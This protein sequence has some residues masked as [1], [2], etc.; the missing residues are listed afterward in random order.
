MKARHLSFALLAFWSTAALAHDARSASVDV[1]VAGPLITV[2]L[3][4]SQAGLHYALEAAAGH[5]VDATSDGYRALVADHL[6]QTLRLSADG[7]P[8]QPGEIGLRLG[9]HQSDA[10]FVVELP[11]GAQSLDITVTS[12]D[13]IE[14]QQTVVRVHQEGESTRAVL[15]EADGQTLSVG[16]GGA[17]APPQENASAAGISSAALAGF[18]GIAVLLP[19]LLVAIRRSGTAAIE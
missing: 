18:A 9:D 14:G 7:R 19:L 13:G 8:L 1:D 10:R 6:R 5:S 4:V 2:H 16:L 15:S 3:A 12:F 17:V 11:V